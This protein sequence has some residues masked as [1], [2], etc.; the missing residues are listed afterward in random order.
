MADQV[1]G[2]RLLEKTSTENISPK[3]SKKENK[4]HIAEG[5]SIFIIKLIF[6]VCKFTFHL[7]L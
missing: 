3:R 5:N 1:N 7:T 4:S 6:V 2:K